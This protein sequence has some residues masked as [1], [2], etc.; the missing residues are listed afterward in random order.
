MIALLVIKLPLIFVQLVGCHS[1]EHVLYVQSCNDNHC[2][3]QNTLA[4]YARNNSSTRFKLESGKHYL[5]E[6]FFV[7]NTSDFSFVNANDSKSMIYCSPNASFCFEHVSNLTIEDMVFHSC[8]IYMLNVTVANL[9]DLEL[10]SCSNAALRIE[11][12]HNILISNLALRDNRKSTTTLMAFKQSEIKLIGSTDIE[13]NTLEWPFYYE[14]F[15]C[16]SHC[17]HN[18]SGYIMSDVIFQIKGCTI[19]IESLSVTNNFGPGGVVAVFESELQVSGRS[20]FQKNRVCAGGSLSLNSHTNAVFIGNISF[21]ENNGYRSR[22]NYI[23][24]IFC[25]FI[26]DFPTASLDNMKSTAGMVIEQSSFTSTGCANFSHNEGDIT[27][28]YIKSSSASF[29]CYIS[30]KNTHDRRNY[31]FSDPCFEYGGYSTILMRFSNLIIVNYSE[32]EQNGDFYIFT[33]DDSV[34]DISGSSNFMKNYQI[35]N[36]TNST[37]VLNGKYTFQNNFGYF[38]TAIISVYQTSRIKINGQGC[39][40]NNRGV[41][42]G[43]FYLSESTIIFEKHATILFENNIASEYG[44][45]IYLKASRENVVCSSETSDFHKLL[46]SMLQFEND[47]HIDL[48][49]RGNIAFSAGSVLYVEANGISYYDVDHPILSTFVDISH[50][51]ETNNIP[52]LSSSNPTLQLCFCSLENNQCFDCD[53]AIQPKYAIYK[54]GS[55]SVDVNAINLFGLPDKAFVLSTPWNFTNSQLLGG[56]QSLEGSCTK[57]NYTLSTNQS[58][59]YIEITLLT[60]NLKTYYNYL[61]V[62]VEVR[63]DCPIG[64]ELDSNKKNCICNKKLKS[65]LDECNIDTETF[66]KQTNQ[67]DNWIGFQNGT[68][69]LHNC[70]FGYCNTTDLE[71]NFNDTCN[72]NRSSTLCGQCIQNFSLILGGVRCAE[73]SNDNLAL[74]IPFVVLGIM[75]VVCLFFTQVTVAGGTINGLIIYANIISANKNAFYN[76][77]FPTAYTIFISWLNLDFGIETCFYKGMDQFGYTMLQFVFPF[78][79]WFLVGLIILLCRYS[80]RVSKAFGKGNPVAVLATVILL[81][82]SKLLQTVINIFTVAHLQSPTD[83]GTLTVTKSVWHF[84]GNVVYAQGLHAIFIAVASIIIAVAIVPFTLILTLDQLFQKLQC[85]SRILRYYMKIAPFIKMY[86]EPFKADHR[87]WIGLT[88][89]LRV[90]LLV[91]FASVENT[92]INLVATST[93]CFILICIFASTGGIYKLRWLNILE[94]SFIANLGILSAVTSYTILLSGD[95]NEPKNKV[96]IATT[97]SVTIALITFI[98]IVSLHVYRQLKQLPKFKKVMKSVKDQIKTMKDTKSD[99]PNVGDTSTLKRSIVSSHEIAPPDRFELREPLLD[100]SV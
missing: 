37:L 39:F 61:I 56:I 11:D 94:I 88:L 7:K 86:H 19:G 40:K 38:D 9:S 12:S 5:T 93:L 59:E 68:V 74:I 30:D 20:M 79:L 23:N 69:V 51:D 3:D 13:D 35:F 18:M 22:S 15:M 2:P 25:T 78:Y 27:S 92:K 57:L 73:C 52:Y 63:S 90:C 85:S 82:Y 62:E 80:V 1:Q 77:H 71:F 83:N 66:K 95:N 4:S 65:L 8:S 43:V 64:F 50:I 81:S 72:N 99:L 34:L 54:G 49:F 89:F 100:D 48:T 29:T 21:I 6:N 33:A 44:G 84:D 55:F 41:Y 17:P 28:L 91:I 32:I 47:I 87:Y 76:K 45:A 42:G 60:I 58:I 16:N 31:N 26:D 10:R 24:L 36:L 70:P 46:T 98:G 97:I 53:R 75:L 96:H 67:Q 14:D